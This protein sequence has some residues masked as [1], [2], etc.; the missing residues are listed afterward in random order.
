MKKIIVFTLNIPVFLYR[1]THLVL[2]TIFK[3]SFPKRFYFRKGLGK[4]ATQNLFKSSLAIFIPKICSKSFK[5]SIELLPQMKAY[6]DE[7]NPKD[8]VILKGCSS[9][10]GLDFVF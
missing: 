3:M 6:V 10:G 2:W 7:K 8:L 5:H 4:K 1:I 9:N